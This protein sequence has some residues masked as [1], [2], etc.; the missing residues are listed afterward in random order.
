LVPQN[1]FDLIKSSPQVLLLAQFKRV[2][3]QS[4]GSLIKW[5]NRMKKARLIIF[6]D[7][8]LQPISHQVKVTILQILEDRHE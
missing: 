2:F 3:A 7:F 6:D 4:D 5:L 8:G 1:G